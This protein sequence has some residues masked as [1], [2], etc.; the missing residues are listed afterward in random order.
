M[1]WRISE[2]VKETYP[3]ETLHM[4]AV[5]LEHDHGALLPGF[6]PGAPIS[7]LSS[8]QL[9]ARLSPGTRVVQGPS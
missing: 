9:L 7:F 4:P 3:H 6:H 5:L 8:L 1:K 2:F